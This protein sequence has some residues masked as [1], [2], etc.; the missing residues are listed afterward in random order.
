MTGYTPAPMRS[1]L[2]LAIATFLLAAGIA[3]CGGASGNGVA[4]KS[5]DQIVA[6]AMSAVSGVKSVHVSGSLVSSG[7]PITLNL[8]LVA[9]KGGSGQMSLSGASFRIIALNQT[10]YI[11]GSDAFWHRVAGNAAT[12]NA[13]AQL[14]HG[15]WLKAPAN[16]QLASVG[17][18]TDVQTL[19][20]RLLSNHGTLAKG[21]T[22]TVA[23]QQVVA[24]NDT[25]QGGTLY[26]ATTGKPYPVQISKTGSQGGRVVFDRYNEPVSLSAPPNSVDISKLPSS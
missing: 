6:A 11:N 5:P 24:V 14:F 3:G 25:T 13:A 16:G 9:G 8:T 10:V 7:T 17:S 20:N 23:G 4:A 18:L 2:L 21:G 22:T 26:V 15:K 19:F 1:R 12:G